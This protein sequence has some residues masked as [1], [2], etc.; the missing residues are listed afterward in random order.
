MPNTYKKPYIAGPMRGVPRFNFPAFEVAE[1]YL[2]SVGME[3]Y[4]PARVDIE[5]GYDPYAL[6]DD[7]DW[8]TL[9]E[10]LLMED[11]AQR[12]LSAVI[13]CDSIYLLEGWENSAGARSEVA[14][15]W[16]LKKGFMYDTPATLRYTATDLFLPPPAIPE[17][18]P[19]PPIDILTEALAITQGDRQAQYGPPDQ[20]FR[21]TAAAWEA[22]FGWYVRPDQV[23]AAMI[24]LKLSR[25]QHQR[26]RDNWVDIAGYARCGNICDEAA[27]CK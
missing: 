11:I 25:Q 22:M 7:W 14:V 4:N 26:K 3:P 19:S 15:A 10:G 1:K 5:M 24:I 21:R 12:D 2:I 16:W 9:P 8:W 18:I 17:H 13:D 20:D 23:A 6:P 27:S